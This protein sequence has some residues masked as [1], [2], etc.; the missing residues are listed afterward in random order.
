[1]IQS[2]HQGTRT[3]GFVIADLQAVLQVPDKT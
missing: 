3:D 2:Q 1:M